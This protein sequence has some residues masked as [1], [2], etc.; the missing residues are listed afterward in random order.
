MMI[1]DSDL[2]YL[3]RCVTSGK[4]KNIRRQMI[5]YIGQYNGM[6]E[7]GSYNTW[8]QLVLLMGIAV[9]TLVLV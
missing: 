8:L 4:L 9:L 6:L 1:H 5:Y 7:I 3:K 2:A